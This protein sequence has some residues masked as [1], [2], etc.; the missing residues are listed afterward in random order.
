MND[1]RAYVIGKNGQTLQ[2][3]DFQSEN[4]AAALE[5]SRQYLTDK[6]VEVWQLD[7]VVGT[8]RKAGS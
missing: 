8:L 1:Y 5:H 4:D 6:D 2:R 7:R 3:H